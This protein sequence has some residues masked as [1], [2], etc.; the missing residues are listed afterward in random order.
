[1]TVE[2]S[3][4]GKYGNYRPGNTRYR[5]LKIGHP[6]IYLRP[7]VYSV[8]VLE[9]SPCPRGQGSSRTNFQ[10]LVLGHQVL[11]LVLVLESQVLDNNTGDEAEQCETKNF[12]HTLFLITSLIFDQIFLITLFS[13]IMYLPCHLCFNVRLSYDRL[14]CGAIF[15]ILTGVRSYTTAVLSHLLPCKCA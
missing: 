7:G 9:E 2:T 10:I 15:H 11:V 12:A 8:V 14:Y 6:G 1:M 4:T 5:G 3:D 13:A